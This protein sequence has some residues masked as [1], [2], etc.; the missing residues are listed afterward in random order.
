MVEL[1]SQ[2]KTYFRGRAQRIGATGAVGKAGLTDAVAGTISRLLDRHEL[3]K[4]NIPA[5][6]GE[7]RQAMAD[8]LAQATGAALIAVVGRMVV[9][10]R[11]KADAST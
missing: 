7:E 6:P 4:I 11:P 9:L 8:A 3:V 5:G 10:Y 1:T 2:Q